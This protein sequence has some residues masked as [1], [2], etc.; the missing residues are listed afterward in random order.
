V[1]IGAVLVPLNTGQQSIVKFTGNDKQKSPSDD[2]FPFYNTTATD[3]TLRLS[4]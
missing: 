2:I 3:N 4:Y 1:V